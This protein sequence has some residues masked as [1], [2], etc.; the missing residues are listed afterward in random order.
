MAWVPSGV[1]FWALGL[2]EP[3][4]TRPRAAWTFR[5]KRL[6]FLQENNTTSDPLP[7]AEPGRP[8]AYAPFYRSQLRDAM[9]VERS[10]QS[11]RE[12]GASRYREV[13]TRG[14]K[15]KA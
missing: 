9:A 11:I 13:K 4:D 10:Q 5:G 7:T 12:G 3:G 15:P 14:K 2:A 6:P 8:V 1:M